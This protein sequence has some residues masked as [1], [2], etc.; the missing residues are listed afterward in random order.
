MEPEPVN[1]QLDVSL[2]IACYNEEPVLEG[3]L[4]KIMDVLDQTSYRYEVILVDD[5]SSDGTGNIIE[6]LSGDLPCVSYLLHPFNMG[7]GRA[8][9]DGIRQARGRVVGFIDIDLQTPAHYLPILI[10]EIDMGADVAIARRIYKLTPAVVGRWILSK[11][12]MV[13]SRA[14]LGL[15]RRDTETGCKFFRREVILPVLDHVRDPHW[16][17]DT[18]TMA[19]AEYYGLAIVEV[20]TIF[21][22]QL[23]NRS[24]VRVVPDVFRYLVSLFRFRHRMGR[25]LDADDGSQGVG[26]LKEVRQADIPKPTLEPGVG[27]RTEVGRL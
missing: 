27:A 12:Y 9:A 17:W 1:P 3:N 16:F 23:S 15:E 26:R 2:V 25:L 8:V 22:R 19:L 24:T 13:L 7:R 6:R 10:R 11:G 14:V 5:G 21:V 4:H 20:P 18:E